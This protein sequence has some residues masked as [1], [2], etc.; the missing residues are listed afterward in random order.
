MSRYYFEGD[1]PTKITFEDDSFDL[2]TICIDK[3]GTFSTRS[4]KA[5]LEKKFNASFV[6]QLG[7]LIELECEVEAASNGAVIGKWIDCSY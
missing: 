6:D 5:N 3:S 7:N 1:F 2:T 4:K